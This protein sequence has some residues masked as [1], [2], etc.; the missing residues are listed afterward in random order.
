MKTEGVQRGFH[1][2]AGYRRSCWNMAKRQNCKIAKR[3]DN[4][5]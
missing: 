3:G 5:E 4:E 2:I 1:G